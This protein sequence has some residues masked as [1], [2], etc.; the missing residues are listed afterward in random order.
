MLVLFIT[1]TKVYC[2]NCD[3][4]PRI[5]E[6]ICYKPYYL[7]ES[8]ALLRVV[9]VMHQPTQNVLKNLLSKVQ[10]PEW[11]QSIINKKISILI[12]AEEINGNC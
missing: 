7:N 1:K 5:D 2:I 10:D 12:Q 11:L 4:I 9:S 8:F 6:H 3:T